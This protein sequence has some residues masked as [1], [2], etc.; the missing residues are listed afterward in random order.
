MAFV[1]K[2]VFQLQKLLEHVTVRISDAPER[3]AVLDVLVAQ[4]SSEAPN[5]TELN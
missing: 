1:L 4:G 3:I 2:L 5:S